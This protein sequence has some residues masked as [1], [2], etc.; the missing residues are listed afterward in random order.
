MRTRSVL[1]LPTFETNSEQV[2]QIFPVTGKHLQT[3]VTIVLPSH[4]NFLD[5]LTGTYCQLQDFHIEH[6]TIDQLPSEQLMS[7]VSQ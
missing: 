1:G 3:C 2:F 4:A 7:H 5:A 6:V